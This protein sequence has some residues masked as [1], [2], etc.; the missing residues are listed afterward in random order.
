[1]YIEVARRRSGKTQRII[2]EAIKILRE[3]KNNFVCIV[4]Y[5]RD[6]SRDIIHRIKELTFDSRNLLLSEFS[7]I[8]FVVAY[9][10]IGYISLDFRKYHTVFFDEF[11]MFRELIPISN[12]YYSSSPGNVEQIKFLTGFTGGKYYKRQIAC[13]LLKKEHKRKSKTNLSRQKKIK[14]KIF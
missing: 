14:T 5:S 11:S 2:K 3:N 9:D 6:S 10:R 4:N 7:R 12:G 1:M 8:K 13:K